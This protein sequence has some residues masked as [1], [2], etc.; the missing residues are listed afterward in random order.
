M[1]DNLDLTDLKW[2]AECEEWCSQ[3]TIPELA[4]CDASTEQRIPI[5][6]D[7]S[8]ASFPLLVHNRMGNEQPTGWQCEALSFFNGHRA[9]I[10]GNS[11][12]AILEWY[13]PY[14][15]EYRQVFQAYSPPDDSLD[16]LDKDFPVIDNTDQLRALIALDCVVVHEASRGGVSDI[17]LCFDCCWDDEHGLGVLVNK[18]DVVKMGGADVATEDRYETFLNGTEWKLAPETSG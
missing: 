11:L 15:D 2:D 13:V 10:V 1:T 5:S 9:E 4:S 14:V 8:Q 18:L 7:L 6:T 16:D 3:I 12:Q 17:G